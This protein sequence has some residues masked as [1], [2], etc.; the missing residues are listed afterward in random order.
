MADLNTV[1]PW[2]QH[3]FVTVQ[4]AA[5]RRRRRLQ[6][7]AAESL[8]TVD[9]VTIAGLAGRL[10]GGLATIEDLQLAEKLLLALMQML[11]P[12]GTIGIAP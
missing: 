11:P 6:N 4:P 1:S 8:R 5:R 10:G 2:E 7:P 3:G 12:N 9:T